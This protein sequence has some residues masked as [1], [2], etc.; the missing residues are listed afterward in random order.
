MVVET[1]DH[2]DADRLRALER[3]SQRD[4]SGLQQE[5]LIGD[6]RL[7][8]VWGKEQTDPSRATGATLRALSASLALLP[9]QDGTLRIENSLA[10]AGLKLVFIGSAHLRGRR[11]LLVFTF[12]TLR[13][14]LAGRTLWSLALPPAAKGREPFFALIASRSTTAGT[15]WL[16]ARGRGG[17]LALW[18]QA[19]AGSS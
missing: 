3:D 2:P 1:L 5:D 15:R 8:Q 18:L 6:W 7:N 4:G 17:G 13:V 19:P 14:T 9:A 11:P 10:L 12:D 16:A